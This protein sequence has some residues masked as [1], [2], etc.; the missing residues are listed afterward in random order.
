MSYLVPYPLLL[1]FP[2]TLYTHRPG[3]TSLQ[4]TATGRRHEKD[5]EPYLAPYPLLLLF[6]NMLYTDRPGTT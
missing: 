3:T 1:L 4:T 5:T 6:P 2:D